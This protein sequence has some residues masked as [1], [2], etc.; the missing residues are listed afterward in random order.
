MSFFVRL[1]AYVSFVLVCLLVCV[2]VCVFDCVGLFELLIVCLRVRCVFAM[3]AWLLFGCLIVCVFV[4]V[5]VCLCV[6]VCVYV[7]VRV[8]SCFFRVYAC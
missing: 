7:L 1:F 2:L 8:C 5:C 3:F 6:L 4:C